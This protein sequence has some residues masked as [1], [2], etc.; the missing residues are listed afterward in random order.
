MGLLEHEAKALLKGYRIPVLSGQVVR[1]VEEI[2]VQRPFVLKAQIPV[3]GRKKAG[4]VA[5]AKTQKGAEQETGTLCHI[6]MR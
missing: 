4:R 1:S 2:N 6:L 3:G 5:F